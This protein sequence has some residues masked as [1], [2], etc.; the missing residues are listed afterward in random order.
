MN[1]GAGACLTSMSRTAV[2]SMQVSLD[3]YME[4]PDHDIGW[5]TPD[6]EVHRF[7]NDR[8]RDAG[9]FLYGRRL[10]ELMFGH[11]PT[12]GD[13]PSASPE[14][15]EFARVWNAT[16]RVVFS[17]TLERVDE[18]SRLVRGDA[19]EE[20]ARLKEQPGGE[21]DVGGAALGGSLLRTGLIDEVRLFVY[22]IVLGAGTPFFPPLDHRIELELIDTRRFES[23]VVYLRHRVRTS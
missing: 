16:P 17:K 21:L 22:P 12:A 20:V 19:A 10:Y 18:G 13:D 11:W 1:P 3:G 5:A 2:Y 14:V 15:V 23:G 4:A 6:A 7:H 9:A 8:A